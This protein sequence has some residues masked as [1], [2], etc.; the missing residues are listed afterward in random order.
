MAF[1]CD[2]CGAKTA[3]VKPCGNVSPGGKKITLQIKSSEDIKRFLFRSETCKVLIPELGF[4]SGFSNDSKYTTVEG[5]LEM[6]GS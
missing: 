3:E 2:F 5:L 4:E 1:S 6:I